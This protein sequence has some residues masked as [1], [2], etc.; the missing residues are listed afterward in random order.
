MLAIVLGGAALVALGQADAKLEKLSFQDLAPTPLKATARH[1]LKDRRVKANNSPVFSTDGKWLAVSFFE[2]PGADGCTVAV[3]DVDAGTSRFRLDHPAAVVGK[4]FSGESLYTCDGKGTIR[5][6]RLKDGTL[7]WSKETPDKSKAASAMALSADELGLVSGNRRFV[8]WDLKTGGSRILEPAPDAKPGR[9]DTLLLS[10]GED[11]KSI[12]SMA[13]VQKITSVRSFDGLELA[14]TENGTDV[15]FL[16]AAISP[17]RRLLAAGL[18]APNEGQGW[19]RIWNAATLRDFFVA[20][21]FKGY[22][23][24]VAFS[25]DGRYLF[26]LGSD[27]QDRGTCL[28]IL[29]VPARKQAAAIL[30]RAKGDFLNFAVSNTN[31][32]AIS[33]PGDGEVEIFDLQ[34][35]LDP[36]K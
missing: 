8:F 12:L 3:W 5:K 36:K 28:R 30:L 15:A 18:G 20:Q 25:K 4:A 33:A 24:R 7:E 27:A 11:G 2:E 16:C 31:Q 23:S 14:R 17:D 22:V 10:F 9:D 26:V 19:V 29:D 13:H 32:I 1:F 6:W 34:D 35:L 21:C